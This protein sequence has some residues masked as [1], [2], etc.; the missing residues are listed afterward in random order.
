MTPILLT[1]FG[2]FSWATTVAAPTITA[3]QSYSLYENAADDYPMGTVLFTGNTPTN[4]RF[5][6]SSSYLSADD[7]Y[8]CS[9]NDP[10]LGQMLLRLIPSATRGAGFAAGGPTN[11]GVQMSADGGKT[12]SASV[13]VAVSVT[14]A[15]AAAQQN[16]SLNIS[17]SLNI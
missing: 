16:R 7:Y 14:A 8:Y 10:N 4:M 5:S 17:L 12:W 11:Y 3:S 2:G 13:N 6:A 1:F 9:F 15:A